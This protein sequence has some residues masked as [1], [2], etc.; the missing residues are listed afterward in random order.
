MRELE[1]EGKVALVTGA[2]RERGLGRAIALALA[3]AGA[4]VAVTGKE[5]GHSSLTVD[6]REEGWRG[7]PDVV[8]ELRSVGVQAQGHYVDVRS[9]LE[10]QQ[11]VDEVVRGLGRVD[12]LV[13]NATY[14][15]ADDRVRVQDLDDD[16]WREIVA[17]NLTGTMLVSK[18]V[19]R[20]MISQGSGGSIV[21]ISSAA[22]LK[23]PPTFS[24]YAASKAGIH[25]LMA[26]L[27]AELAS[28]DITVNVVAPGF[29]DTARVDAIRNAQQWESRLSTIPAGRPGTV[30]EVAD[31][32][33]YLCGPKAR[34]MTGDVL[35]ITGGEV[36]R[37]AR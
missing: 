16:L 15:R 34:W 12:I 21:A 28:D 3:R 25:A 7:L 6:E 20:Q 27:S 9:S 19:S 1:L 13:N 14:P 23:S 31:L 30:E 2:T 10:I 4:D 36:R 17:V 32:V 8:E 11:M 35:L 26:C 22:A 29:L 24:A 18:Y 33:C 5:R 37:S